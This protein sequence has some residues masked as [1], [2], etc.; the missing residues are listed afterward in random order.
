MSESR[1]RSSAGT[2]TTDVGPLK[3]DRPTTG[4]VRYR[5]AIRARLSSASRW[6]PSEAPSARRALSVGVVSATE[7][8]IDSLTSGFN[9]V[10]AIQTDA[11]INRGN[12][13][14]RCSTPPERVIGI[15]ADPERVRHRRGRRLRDPDQRGQR[16]MVAPDPDGR[17]A[18][19]LARRHDA[20]RDT[21]DRLTGSASP[22]GGRRDQSVPGGSPADWAGLIGGGAVAPGRGRSA[23][24]ISSSRSGRPRSLAE[25]VVRA[26]NQQRLPGDE[27]RLVVPA[28]SGSSWSAKL[29]DR[30]PIRR[31]WPAA[32]PDRVGC[33]SGSNP[34]RG[35]PGDPGELRRRL[36][37][38]RL[39]GSPLQH[40][41]DGGGG[42]PSRSRH[43]WA[44][45]GWA[46]A[47][48]HGILA[49]VPPSR[50]PTTTTS[51]SSSLASET[52]PL[53]WTPT[54]KATRT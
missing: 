19:R 54:W 11:P 22:S 52:P 49:R 9:L 14:G 43:T 47:A 10:D 6:R 28:A 29:G 36:L 5:S 26:V 41:A 17:G 4:S 32:T 21:A 12:P 30:P 35:Q 8:S 38:A 33:A 44:A 46:S 24:A 16:S 2:S 25:D 51:A 7:R 53:R 42:S 23:G 40:R 1:R 3:V 45:T 34:P 15:D 50:T 13:A 20:D 39:R 18:L 27:I 48:R 31:R 37:P